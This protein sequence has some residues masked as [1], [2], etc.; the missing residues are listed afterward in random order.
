MKKILFY[1]G[2]ALL[3]LGLT[4]CGCKH[5]TWNP[6]DCLT[7][8]TCA[9]CGETEGEALGHNWVEASCE[10]PKT[11]SLCKLTEGSA[12]GHSWVDANCDFPKTCEACKL[13]EG[14]KLAHTW[15][16]ATTEAPMTCTA[17]G[18]TAGDRIITDPRFTTANNQQLFGLWRAEISETVPDM[19]LEMTMY[20]YMD[21]KNDGSLKLKMELKDPDGFREAMTKASIESAYAEFAAQGYN[22]QA[23]D[24][25]FED[26]YGKGIEAYFTEVMAALDMNQILGSV[27]AVSY[28][29][30]VD[31]NE[32]NIGMGWEGEMSGEKF[33]IEE[34]VLCIFDSTDSALPTAFYRV[35]E[36]QG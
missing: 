35:E 22:K 21:F 16:D 10:T 19:N 25:A 1:V 14:E 26:A 8:K 3:L 32:L 24:K 27:N 9:E 4:A 36:T 13:T 33:T 31:K 17:C 23:A 18:D 2:I 12:L 29:Y 7:P 11:C 30:Y 20:V 5:E 28:V 6:A 15:A 34:G